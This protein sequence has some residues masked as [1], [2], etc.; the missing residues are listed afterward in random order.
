VS[1]RAD[2]NGPTGRAT[3]TSTPAR[4][5]AQDTAAALTSRVASLLI[6]LGIQASLAWFLGP[7][8]RGSYAVCLLY[9]N[10]LGLGLHFAMDLAGRYAVASG[11]LSK[12]EAVW[13][14][15]SALLF[16]SAV[17]IVV[18]RLLMETGLPIFEK[19]S[20]SAFVVALAVIPFT[21]FGRGCVSL[22]VGLGRIAWMAVMV[23]AGF[24]AQLIAVLIFVRVLHMG[25]EG[26]LLA[27]AAGGATRVVF[28][29]VA[30][31]QEGAYRRVRLRLEH[32]R[33][34]LSY[35]LRSYIERVGNTVNVRV[36][37]MVLAFF[38][39]AG[40]I[41]I[42]AAAS[43]LMSQLLLLPNS[44][45]NAL[46]HRVASDAAGRPDVVSQ[47][48]RITAVV[49]AAGLA[50]LCALAWPIVAVL[51]SPRFLDAVPLI[52]IM[53]PG[54]LMRATSK[55]LVPFFM[56]TDRPGICSWAV[57]SSIVVNITALLVLLPVMGLAGAALAMTLGFLTSSVILVAAFRRV[58]GMSLSEA[59]RPRMDDVRRVREALRDL[60]ERGF[61]HRSGGE[62]VGGGNP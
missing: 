10:L 22:L 8:G 3:A 45:A 54:V 40:E 35:G 36:G 33:L 37:T 52:W 59:W 49:A 46:F 5:G 57:G 2:V 41:G 1:H 50:V 11:R 21:L 16:S 32:Y 55:V 28:A 53:A 27:L 60:R 44:V 6:T 7:A 48:A 58:T 29:A 39:T 20:H 56:G 47:S 12:P 15:A 25:V 51:L 38:V 23:V 31:R 4:T 13:S 19:A 26:A 34:L 43:G 42:F 30:L 24:L 14:T 61:G 9:G 62:R 18:G 17:A